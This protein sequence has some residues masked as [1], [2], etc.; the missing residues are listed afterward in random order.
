M[1]AVECVHWFKIVADGIFGEKTSKFC[2]ISDVVALVMLIFAFFPFLG[3]AG[4]CTV[5]T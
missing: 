3:D 1:V 5:A 2:E 4:D